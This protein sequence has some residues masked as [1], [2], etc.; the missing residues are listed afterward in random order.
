MTKVQGMELSAAQSR[1][2]K[3]GK[4]GRSSIFRLALERSGER[5]QGLISPAVTHRRTARPRPWCIASHEAIEEPIIFGRLTS[6]D[7]SI[8]GNA[9]ESTLLDLC[10][11]KKLISREVVRSWAMSRDLEEALFD[12]N[13]V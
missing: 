13:T 12:P 9:W 3:H 2:G 8:R 5:D 10:L 1:I 6:K 4:Y 11:L 7:S